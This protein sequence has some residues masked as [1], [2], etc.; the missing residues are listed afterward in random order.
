MPI[1]EMGEKAVI[2]I[3]V[4]AVLVMLL[5]QHIGTIKLEEH[6]KNCERPEV[7]R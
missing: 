4:S 1:G 2:S 7:Q 3:L 5:S 6:T